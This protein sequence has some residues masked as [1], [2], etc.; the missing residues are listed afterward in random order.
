MAVEMG[1]ISCDGDGGG[2][3]AVADVQQAIV[4]AFWGYR[5]CDDS[6]TAVALRRGNSGGT[7]GRGHCEIAVGAVTATTSATIGAFAAVAAAVAA[8]ERGD[9]CCGMI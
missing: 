1:R 6:A 4:I 8:S 3:R 2:G 7:L 9:D 5:C